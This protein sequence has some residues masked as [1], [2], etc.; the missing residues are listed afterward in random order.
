MYTRNKRNFYII[1]S[2]PQ[3]F[4]DMTIEGVEALLE[5]DLVILSKFFS[6]T[7]VNFLKENKK[8][9]IF[10]EDFVTEITLWESIYSLCKKNNTIALLI[11]GDPH[12]CEKNDLENFLKKRKINV[13]KILG[14][15][16]IVSWVNEKNDFLTNREKNSSVFFFIPSSLA[17]IKKKILNK[18]L[19]GKLI[20]VFKETK[21]LNNLLKQFKKENKIEYKLYINGDKQNLRNMPFTLE[22]QFSNAYLIVNYE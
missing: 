1:G 6:K 12:F 21:L 14:L 20:F 18:K 7:Y 17:E 13:I 22:S 5:C 10:K 19:S 2:N 16:E 3:D 4:F 11:S 9:F 8:K 15:L